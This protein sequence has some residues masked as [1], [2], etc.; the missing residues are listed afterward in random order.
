MQ[1]IFIL[2]V[3]VE[4]KEKYPSLEQLVVFIKYFQFRRDVGSKAEE[5]LLSKTLAKEQINRNLNRNLSV[6]GK[7]SLPGAN[8]VVL[9]EG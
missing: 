1:I 4:Q 3:F 9:G 2:S 6:G 8:L 7:G 5:L